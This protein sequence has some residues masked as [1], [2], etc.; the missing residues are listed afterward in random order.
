MRTKKQDPKQTTQENK[1]LPPTFPSL[2]DQSKLRR[3]SDAEPGNHV[4]EKEKRKEE[5]KG[6]LAMQVKGRKNGEKKKK[7]K[8]EK[9]RRKTKS[10]S[11]RA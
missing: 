9:K 10:K 7:R 3:R 6:R 2:F 8:K 11:K 1:S 5:Q 4:C